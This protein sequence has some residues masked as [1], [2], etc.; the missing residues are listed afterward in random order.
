MKLERL[1]MWPAAGKHLPDQL[2]L[3]HIERLWLGSHRAGLSS[4]CKLL[5]EVPCQCSKLFQVPSSRGQSKLHNKV[6]WQAVLCISKD[7]SQ[8][9]MGMTHTAEQHGSNPKARACN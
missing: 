9:V 1:A 8:P 2:G 6:V 7:L 4:Q 3:A 5:V